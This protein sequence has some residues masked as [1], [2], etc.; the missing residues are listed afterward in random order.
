MKFEEN[1]NEPRHENK[2][3]HWK[4]KRNLLSLLGTEQH[5]YS[6]A[7]ESTDEQTRCP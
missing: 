1:R 2:S 6:A 7:I 3:Y 4:K 5:L